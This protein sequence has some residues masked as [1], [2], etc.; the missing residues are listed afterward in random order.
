LLYFGNN[1]KDYEIDFILNN[2]IE[3]TQMITAGTI[4]SY[5]LNFDNI[6]TYEFVLSIAKLGIDYRT[7]LVVERYTGV[8]P[9]INLD[10]DA[11][12]TYLTA[13]GRTNNAA[14]KE[15]WPDYKTPSLKGVLSNFYYRTVNGWMIDNDGVSYLKV[16]QGAQVVFDKYSPY[17]GNPKTK[18]ITIELDFKLS[19]ILDYSD[20]AHLIECVSLNNNKKIK[21]GFYVTGD[22]FKYYASSKANPLVSLDLVSDQRIRLTFVIEPENSPSNPNPFPMC[23]TYLN[24]ILSNAYSY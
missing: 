15:F 23:Y 8:L 9:V 7:S 11:L 12:K 4:G 21:T 17:D 5:N 3:T 19:G 10:N 22:K 20:D 1:T 2:K 6:G 24:G 14:D 18:G 13:K 16:S